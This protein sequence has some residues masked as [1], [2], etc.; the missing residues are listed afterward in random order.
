MGQDPHVRHERQAESER[1]ADHPETEIIKA[2]PYLRNHPPV[3][4]CLVDRVAEMI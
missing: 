3:L 1:V 2:P 4:D